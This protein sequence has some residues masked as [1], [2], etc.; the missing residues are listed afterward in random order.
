MGLE[1]RRWWSAAW[2]PLSLFWLFLFC[3]PAFAH[4]SLV[5]AEPAKGARLERAPEE[6]RLSFSEPVEA[7]FSPVEVY[8]SGG[9]RVDLDD[10]RVASEDAR[11]VIAGLEDISEGAYEV[12]WRVTAVDGHVVDGKHEFAVSDSGEAGGS[13]NAAP[14][15]ES[16]NPEPADRKEQSE[17][18]EVASGRVGL[19]S[20]LSA[21]VVGFAAVAWF[22]VSAL[23]RRE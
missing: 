4:A 3:A 17:G 7:E 14:D 18:R 1:K 21:G 10:A 13:A 8:D 2:I 5:E 16:R 12:Q 22:G 15:E 23:R 19:Y 6:I 9:E 20:V 11:V